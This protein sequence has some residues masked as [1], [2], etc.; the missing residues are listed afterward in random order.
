MC[1]VKY[2]VREKWFNG[3]IVANGDTINNLFK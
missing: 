3:P 2:I 1:N